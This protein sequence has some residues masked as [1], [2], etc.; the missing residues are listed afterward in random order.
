MDDDGPPTAGTPTGPYR[1]VPELALPGRES[2]DGSW[3]DA[4]EGDQRT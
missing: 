1:D 2:P 4:S 3:Q